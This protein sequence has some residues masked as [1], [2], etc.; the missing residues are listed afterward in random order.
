MTTADPLSDPLANGNVAPVAANPPA[1]DSQA[2]SALPARKSSLGLLL[3][4]LLIL[5]VIGGGVAVGG[6][7]WLGSAG[8]GLPTAVGG[9]SGGG[10]AVRAVPVDS[11]PPFTV[12]LAL[13]SPTAASA[14]ESSSLAKVIDDLPKLAAALAPQLHELPV[15][16]TAPPRLIV[17]A[18]GQPSAGDN[19]S[20]PRHE[21]WEV[22]FP[23]G[24][25]IESYT[26]Q[27]D[28]FKIELG[29]IGGSDQVT[30]LSSLAEP[31]PAKRTGPA[32]DEQRLYLIWRRGDMRLADEQLA[33][34]AQVSLAGKVVAH[35]CPLELE[36]ML[37]AIEDAYAARQNIAKIRRT[38]FGIRSR[39]E[40]AFEFYVI[41]MQAE[42][43]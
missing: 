41:A 35:F 34:R 18:G 21:R 6:W 17:A 24:N 8:A 7:L 20:Y 19:S 39:G 2:G 28:F 40:N 23:P 11:P 1:A 30:Y 33:A 10:A 32:T 25:T 16:P 36:A 9:S 27:M 42:P 22:Q 5:L 37:A 3:V 12:Q 13:A 38:T 43:T 26:R 29:L 31:V 14:G 15:D 4:G